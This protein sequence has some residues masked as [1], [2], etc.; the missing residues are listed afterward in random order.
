LSVMSV[1]SVITGATFTSQ[2]II[3][4]A[5]KALAKAG[6]RNEDLVR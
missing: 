6:L 5:A 1:K 4:A 2:G 3:E